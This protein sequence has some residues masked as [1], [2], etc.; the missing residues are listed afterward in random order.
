MG[1]RTQRYGSKKNFYGKE[2]S[3]FL[4]VHSSPSPDGHTVLPAKA[5]LYHYRVMGNSR[6]LRATLAWVQVLTLPLA[7]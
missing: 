7:S 6:G 1:C 5:S 2:H 3:L 4:P